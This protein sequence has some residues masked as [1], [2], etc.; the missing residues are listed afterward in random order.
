[1]AHFLSHSRSSVQNVTHLAVRL[2]GGT[3]ST[4]D[5]NDIYVMPNTIQSTS[6]RLKVIL[7]V[8]SL[9]L[10]LQ[11]GCGI[12]HASGGHMTSRYVNADGPSESKTYPVSGFSSIYLEGN[13]NVTLRQGNPSVRIDGS[14]N[15]LELVNVRVEDNVLHIERIGRVTFQPKI[16]IVITLPRLVNFASVGI[17]DLETS[18]S[19]LPGE[20]VGIEISGSGNYNFNLGARHVSVSHDGFGN[21]TLVGLAETLTAEVNATGSFDSR[22]LLTEDVSISVNGVGGASVHASRRLEARANGIGSITY[23]GNP[24]TVERRAR[25]IGRISAQQ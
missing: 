2:T 5:R 13:G 3:T 15:Q 7:L 23:R 16:D 6:T 19:P 22:N 18:G 25:G 8:A 17:F 9:V 21:V 20:R 1:M 4:H 10:A 24:L 11:T 12:R 14:A